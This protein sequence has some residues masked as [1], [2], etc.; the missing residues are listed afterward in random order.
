MERALIFDCD[1]VLADT[2]PYGHLVAFNRMW[3]EFGVPWNWSIEQY[4]EKL[5]IGGGKER[6]ASLFDEADFCCRA[7]V[8]TS[9]HERKALIAQWHK[10]KTQIYEQIIESGE[11]APRPGIARLSRKAAETGWRLAVASTSAPPAVRAVLSRVVGDLTSEFSIFAGDIVAAKKPAPD[12]YEVALRHLGLT[13]RQC[14][15]IEDS[16]NG[17]LAA[18]GAHL[19]VLIT[20][21]EFTADEC[22]DEA[23]LVVDSLGDPQGPRCN[24][25]SGASGTS[26]GDFITLEDIEAL[27]TKPG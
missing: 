18:R 1:G 7:A 4:R 20:V 6:M 13:A 23:A 19:P 3:Q 17:L 25:M 9:E 2:E 14:V 12:I 11:I 15:A 5:K 24:V 22:F 26:V 16:R 10:R 8:P 21:S 27:M